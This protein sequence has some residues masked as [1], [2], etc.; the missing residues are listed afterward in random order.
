MNVL[1]LGSSHVF[2]ANMKITITLNGQDHQLTVE[3][4]RDLFEQLKSVFKDQMTIVYKHEYPMPIVIN[5]APVISPPYPPQYQP[6]QPPNFG[7]DFPKITCSNHA[8]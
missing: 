8:G 5:P 6:W 3:E 1:T 7:D 4:A 2:Y